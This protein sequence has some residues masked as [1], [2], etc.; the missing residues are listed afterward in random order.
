M[1]PSPR[2]E[3]EETVRV[4]LALGGVS[5]QERVFAPSSARWRL[6]SCNTLS[7]LRWAGVTAAAFS[8]PKEAICS[9]D[10]SCSG[11][12]GGGRDSALSGSPPRVSKTSVTRPGPR[13]TLPHPCTLSAPL[14][15]LS[16]KSP[17]S[18]TARINLF[19]KWKILGRL[20]GSVG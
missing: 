19:L 7:C 17:R 14:E 12:G 5:S 18:F 16:L 8:G 1:F 2:V 15:D 9:A 20:G 3:A 4:G 10:S 11:K 6:C 13:T